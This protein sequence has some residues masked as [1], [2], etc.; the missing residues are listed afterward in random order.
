MIQNPSLLDGSL[1]FPGGLE[2]KESACDS[3]DLGSIPGSGRSPRE[4][5]SNLL[6]YFHLGNPM[7]RGAWRATVHGVEKSRKRLI[8]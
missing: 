3:G 2:G 4:G 7:D 5:N 6:Q 1:S 8:D